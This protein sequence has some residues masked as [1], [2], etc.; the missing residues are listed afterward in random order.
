MR[1]RKK[2]SNEEQALLDN[3]LRMAAIRIGLQRKQKM[4]KEIKRMIISK[5]ISEI[6]K[7]RKINSNDSM[8][9]LKNHENKENSF[10]WVESVC[11]GGTR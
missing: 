2:L 11:L 6:E 1:Y 3:T 5:A 10:S 8:T 4:P 7:R 9:G